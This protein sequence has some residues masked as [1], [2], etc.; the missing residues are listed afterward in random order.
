LEEAAG[1]GLARLLPGGPWKV[2]GGDLRRGGDVAGRLPDSVGAQER[3]V[4]R[5]GREEGAIGGQV[6]EDDRLTARQVDTEAAAAGADGGGVEDVQDL[7][8]ELA[9]R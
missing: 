5:A 2:I 1:V 4:G 8:D 7:A 6:D 3:G 9:G